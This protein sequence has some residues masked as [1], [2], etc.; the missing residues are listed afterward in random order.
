MMNEVMGRSYFR[1]FRKE[2]DRIDY[3]SKASD[4]FFKRLS[5][6]GV[7][8]PNKVVRGPGKRK[9]LC[10]GAW[11]TLRTLNLIGLVDF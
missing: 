3:K 7:F 4:I 8:C 11:Y 2:G 5:E 9:W 6:L 1:Y 10:S